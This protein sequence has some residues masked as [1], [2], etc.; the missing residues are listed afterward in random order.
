MFG[1]NLSKL[2]KAQNISGKELARSTGISQSTIS[3]FLS[4]NQEPRYSQII[5]LAKAVHL[6]PGAFLSVISSQYDAA[7][8]MINECCMIRETYRDASS[9]L[10]ITTLHSFKEFTLDLS[11]GIYDE[12]IYVS[13]ILKG[14]SDSKL[15]SLR[16]GDYQIVKGTE[17]KGLKVAVLKDT[18]LI[19]Y[20]MLALPEDTTKSWLR[21]H[22]E[23]LKHQKCEFLK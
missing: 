19:S 23:G 3:K 4:G 7:P 9:N 10:H 20:K 18:M 8:P 15:G 16:A 14:G 5:Q 13:V 21:L 22:F 1:E 2:M 6:P 17:Y 11:D 12:A